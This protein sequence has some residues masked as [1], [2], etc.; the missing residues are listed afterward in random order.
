[1]QF[2]KQDTQMQS[3]VRDDAVVCCLQQICALY[4]NKNAIFKELLLPL[5][6]HKKWLILPVAPTRSPS[7]GTPFHHPDPLLIHCGKILRQSISWLKRMCESTFIST[8]TF[9]N[10]KTK[11]IYHFISCVQNRC[12][13]GTE[14]HANIDLAEQWYVSKILFSN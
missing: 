13:Q 1:M 3:E 8:R 2:T 6:W 9:A 12:F 11:F 10:A 5:R 14:G 7:L 4:E